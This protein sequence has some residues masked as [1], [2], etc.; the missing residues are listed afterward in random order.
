MFNKNVY[1]YDDMK[2]REHMAVRQNI[3]WYL[4]THQ[5][6]E[7]TGTQ[8]MDFLDF[9]FPNPIANLKSGRER[10]TVMLDENAEIIDDVV[11]MHMEENRFWISTL[12]LRD[13]TLWFE[14]YKKNYDVTYRDVTGQYHM[15]AVQGPNATEMVNRIVDNDI[16]NLKFFSFME[17]SIGNIPVI[18]NRAGFTGEKFGY[19][20]YIAADKVNYLEEKLRSTAAEMGAVEVT[21]F[22]VMTGTLPTEAGFYYMRD[23]RHC[24]PLEVGLDKN[25]NWEKD[26]IGKDAL[27]KIKE[28]GA[29]REMVGFMLES[30]V[31]V[32]INGKDQGGAGSAVFIGQEEIGRVS[33]FN[34]SYIHEKPVGYIL[35]SKNTLKKGMHVA[36]N[37]LYDAVITE[38]VFL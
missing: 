24:N 15:Y 20:I 6:L 3:G 7:V 30:E 1:K 19:E 2:R 14:K 12:F 22:Q 26:F 28:T 33:K 17:N 5:L 13:M 29:K 31:D 25:I 37:K 32:R 8:A 18:V 11:I 23:L 4:W 36:I 27:L 9:I 38:K 34:Y 35:A 10:Y 16:S 21:E